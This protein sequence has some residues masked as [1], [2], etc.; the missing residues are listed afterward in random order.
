MSTQADTGLDKATQERDGIISTV[1][2]VNM[3][4]Q[5]VVS[6]VFNLA[7]KYP[8]ARGVAIVVHQMIVHLETI[9][10]DALLS[11]TLKTG[12]TTDL[13]TGERRYGAEKVRN[14]LATYSRSIPVQ[15]SYLRTVEAA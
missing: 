10:D 6:T 5:D 14:L 2:T 11:A 13:E 12:F 3:R 1:Q 8:A 9:I 15:E 4:P 7:D